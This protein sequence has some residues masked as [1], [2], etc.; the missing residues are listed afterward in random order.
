MGV[1]RKGKKDSKGSDRE[2]I[3]RKVKKKAE[4][5]KGMRKGTI[6]PREDHSFGSGIGMKVGGERIR[7]GRNEEAGGLKGV[8]GADLR[9]SPL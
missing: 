8:D 9:R 5:E 3:R 7:E 1:R 4:E 6:T 2:Q